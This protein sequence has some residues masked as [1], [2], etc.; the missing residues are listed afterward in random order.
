[1]EPREDE[2][3]IEELRDEAFWD[4]DG[5]LVFEEDDSEVQDRAYGREY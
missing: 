1:M 5:A 2:E 3:S 4:D